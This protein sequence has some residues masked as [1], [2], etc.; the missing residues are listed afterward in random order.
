M[1]EQNM[2][3]TPLGLHGCPMIGP[4]LIHIVPLVNL[5]LKRGCSFVWATQPIPVSA[6]LTILAWGPLCGVQMAHVQHTA[7]Q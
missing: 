2:L 6:A 3:A 1:R 5:V 4:R 7:C